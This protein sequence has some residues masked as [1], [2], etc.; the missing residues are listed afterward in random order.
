MIGRTNAG[1]SKSIA[2][3]RV[4]YSA[5]T[6]CTCSN[7]V[8]TYGSDASGDYLFGLPSAGNWTVSGVDSKGTAKTVTLVIARGDAKLVTLDT[9]IP[10]AY[11]ATYQEVEYLQVIHTSGNIPLGINS[12]TGIWKYEV[13]GFTPVALDGAIVIGTQIYGTT[14]GALWINGGRPRI[15]YGDNTETSPNALEQNIAKKLTLTFKDCVPGHSFTS[16]YASMYLNDSEILTVTSTGR[17]NSKEITIGWSQDDS[18]TGFLAKYGIVKISHKD[19][20]AGEYTVMGHLVPCIQRPVAPDT[21]GLPGY[22]NLVTN[23]FEQARFG[24]SVVKADVVNGVNAG[25][26][27]GT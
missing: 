10:P 7:G 16:P 13:E 24:T 14:G 12:N 26:A 8:V 18:I 22:F 25:P 21:V 5:G 20:E 19:S 27:I 23:T 17:L 4:L 1:S 9:M 3:I 2:L 11:R 6:S 15:Y